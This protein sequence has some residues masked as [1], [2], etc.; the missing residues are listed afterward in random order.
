MIDWEA[1][2]TTFLADNGLRLT[3]QR[4]TI[5]RV[6]FAQDGHFNM[7]DLH[8]LVRQE[9][10]NVGQATIYRTLK[11]LVESGLAKASRFGGDT[12]RYEVAEEMHHDH[13]ICLGC[14]IIVEFVN[15]MIETLQDRIAEEHHFTMLDHTMELY[16][17]CSTCIKQGRTA[18]EFKKAVPG[19]SS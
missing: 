6:F 13:L 11:L 5:A 1:P 3:H 9:D 17:L 4:R 2:F 16:G 12:A 19:R 7:E 18:A 15:A 10:S 14:G 8:Q